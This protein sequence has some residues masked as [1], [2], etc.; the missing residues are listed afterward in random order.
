VF[1]RL[2]I[3][4]T[5]FPVRL[6]PQIDLDPGSDTLVRSDQLSTSGTVDH[7]GA[8]YLAYGKATSYLARSFLQ[9]PTT[10]FAGGRITSAT[11]HLWNWYSGSCTQTGWLVWN[12]AAYNNPIYWDTQPALLSNDGYSTQTAGFSTA[13]NDAWVSASVQPFFQRAADA[14]AST[15][16][17]GLSSYNETNPS[18]SWKQ[19]RSL[20]AADQAQVPYVTVTYD[21]APFVS[22]PQAAPTNGGC[23]AGDGRPFATSKTPQLR[24]TVS[25]ADT[26]AVSVTFE[27][28]VTGGSKIGDA[29]VGAVPSGTVASTTVPAGV[30]QEAG[31]YSWRAK[32]TDGSY[33]SDWS[34][35]CEFTVDTVRPAVPIVSSAGYPPISTDNSW[36]HGAYNQAGD[37]VLTPAAGT[38][39]LAA[40]VYQLD[41][42]T[43]PT[44]VTATAATTVSITP[45]EDGQRTLRVWAKDRAGN[46][47]DPN[48]YTFN[49]G[50]AGLTQPRP[51]A[52]V[53]KRTKLA[54]DGDS[55]YTR[56]RYQYRRG[57]GGTE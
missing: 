1:A 16:Y 6:D 11:L 22:A 39:D 40:F 46:Q 31:T 36:G 38:G 56:V 42:Q 32:A 50:R 53:V 24:T 7:S 19:V 18:L 14:R 27:W 48:V 29:T 9:W 51:G 44:T 45:G 20:Q 52:N 57:P 35:W 5:V 33:S 23:V 4:A 12:T 3:T 28:W 43:S 37:F 47:S 17:M 10:Q 8:N 21:A 49:V 41:N 13:C 25:D 26:P 30:L 2:K 15:A 34:A 54:I 55:T